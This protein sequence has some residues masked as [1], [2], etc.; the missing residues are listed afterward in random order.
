MPQS[1]ITNQESKHTTKYK[2]WSTKNKEKKLSA[3][4]AYNQL[5]K[6]YLKRRLEIK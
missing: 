6:D 5:T 4:E 1:Q 2:K 3:K